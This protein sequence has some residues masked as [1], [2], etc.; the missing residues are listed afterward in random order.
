MGF[1]WSKIKV[2]AV[3]RCTSSARTTEARTVGGGAPAGRRPARAPT[4]GAGVLD[5]TSRADTA[6]S[7]LARRLRS[8][9]RE[10]LAEVA[11]RVKGDTQ[12]SW[13][14]YQ[15]G[16]WRLFSPSERTAT[17]DEVR[18]GKRRCGSAW[19]AIDAARER[20]RERL[21]L[22]LLHVQL[23]MTGTL[24]L[25]FLLSQHKVRRLWPAALTRALV[26]RAPARGGPLVLLVLSWWSS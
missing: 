13:K 2:R 23:Y 18:N 25:A 24:R 9:R 4:I 11:E 21:Y 3:V 10:L 5:A 26:V 22:A 7:V 1:L 14:K 16:W 15:L 6:L 20:D 17:V 19:H 8:R 12:S